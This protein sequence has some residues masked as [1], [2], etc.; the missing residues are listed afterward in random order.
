M[1]LVLERGWPADRLIEIRRTVADANDGWPWLTP[2]AT[3]GGL[4][5]I[6]VAAAAT[7]DVAA[8][9]RTWVE[10]AYAAWVDHHGEIRELTARVLA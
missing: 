6:D 10:A 8:V 9:V 3:M 4:G 7:D 1:Q 5:A 2:P